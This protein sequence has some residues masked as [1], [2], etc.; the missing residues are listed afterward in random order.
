[1]RREKLAEDSNISKDKHIKNDNAEA[2]VI[3]IFDCAG[4]LQ[5]AETLL[6]L[7]ITLDKWSGQQIELVTQTHLG[8]KDA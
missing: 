1:M 5:L 4:M 2:V 6:G 3:G 8:G 7:N